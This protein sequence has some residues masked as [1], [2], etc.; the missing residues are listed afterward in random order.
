M[1]DSTVCP[2]TDE[3]RRMVSLDDVACNRPEFGGEH[4]LEILA[5]PMLRY[6]GMDAE[7]GRW[8]GSVA[9]VTRDARSRYDPLPPLLVDGARVPQTPAR[10]ASV[11]GL[12]FWRFPLE[13][14]M[15]AEHSTE[16]TYCWGDEH[17]PFSFWIP[18]RGESMRTMFYSCNGFS[19]TVDPSTFAG[20][21]WMDVARQHADRPF[22]AMLGGGDQ[23]YCD[24]IRCALPE[25]VVD[26]AGQLPEQDAVADLIDQFYLKQY[27]LWYGRGFWRGPEGETDQHKWIDALARIPSVNVFDDHDIIDGYG[28][29]QDSTMARPVFKLIGEYAYRYY[30]LFQQNSHWESD[31][32]LEDACWITTGRPGPYIQHPARSI[33]AQ[34]GAGIGFLGLD[35]RTERTRERICMQET[36]ARVFERLSHEVR[37]NSSVRHIYVMLGVPIAYP[38]MVWAERLMESKAIAPVKWLSKKRIAFKGL[39]NPFDGQVELLDDLNDHWTA[40]PHKLE[41]NQFLKKLL[42]FQLVN[43]VR[44]TILS[45]DVHLCAVGIFQSLVPT[46][47]DKDSNFMVCPVSSAIVN[48]PPP[49]ALAD[50]MNRRNK[51]HLLNGHVMERLIPIFDKDVDGTVLNNKTAMARRNYLVLDPVPQ[52]REDLGR[53]Y[54]GPAF[55]DRTE[56]THPPKHDKY[57]VC[58]PGSVRMALQVERD[59][60]GADGA[61]RAYEMY[62][63]PLD[64]T[65]MYADAEPKR[66]VY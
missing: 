40:K 39:V 29:Y 20:S 55:G 53:V 34:L 51:Q 52:G 32:Q 18:G 35:C 50:F 60:A 28:T 15:D 11:R 62:I 31:P 10:Y 12:S 56:Q 41:R 45:G 48:T 47:P 6:W 42:D 22:H 24:S 8:R 46:P 44:I 49:P 7:Q 66:S 57:T 17:P 2:V 4:S 30:M 59:K 58:V 9:Y 36:Y 16:V 38:R 43:S 5:G 27:T 25:G 13:R 14:E 33:Y 1:K 26:H 54:A 23:L 21:L 3:H 65:D 37:V 61:T 63:P 19:L 64:T